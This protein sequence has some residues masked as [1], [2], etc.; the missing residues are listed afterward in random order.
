M[1]CL[2]LALPVSV[3]LLYVRVSVWAAQWRQSDFWH[4]L[5]EG[6][7]HTCG[8]I[9]L[10]RCDARWT[11][12][13][14]ERAPLI[15]ALYDWL[16]VCLL[17]TVYLLVCYCYEKKLAMILN[18]YPCLTHNLK[19]IMNGENSNEIELENLYA[20]LT[21]FLPCCLSITSVTITCSFYPVSCLP[22][23]SVFY[24]NWLIHCLPI[25]TFLL[26]IMKYVL[27]RA[28]IYLWRVFCAHLRYLSLVLPAAT[29]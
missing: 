14:S 7:R 11:D 13:L 20:C 1:L 6:P 28:V 22:L 9:P 10:V 16:H 24:S 26:F 15:A 29:V 27:L 23:I 25:I 12:F 18:N 5:F 2:L 19:P 4:L 3:C 17:S 8:K 21:V